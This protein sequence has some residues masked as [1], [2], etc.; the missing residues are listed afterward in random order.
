MI[1]VDKEK[2]NW[3]WSSWDLR[4]VLNQYLLLR[5]GINAVV[6]IW[7]HLVEPH[8]HKFHKEADNQ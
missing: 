8:H 7:K 4:L 5:A 2:V 1:I 3:S 6:T